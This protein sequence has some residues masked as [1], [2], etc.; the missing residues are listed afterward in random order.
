MLI[1]MYLVSYMHACSQQKQIIQVGR[2]TQSS[3]QKWFWNKLGS[4]NRKFVKKKQTSLNRHRYGSLSELAYFI[5]T[6]AVHTDIQRYHTTNNLYRQNTIFHTYIFI[7]TLLLLYVAKIGKKE[8]N[9]LQS[10]FSLHLD[11]PH[12]LHIHLATTIRMGLY[13]CSAS[14]IPLA[15]D[16]FHIL[17]FSHNVCMH[18]ILHKFYVCFWFEYTWI[19]YI[20]ACTCTYS[21]PFFVRNRFPHKSRKINKYILEFQINVFRI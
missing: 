1:S 3:E 11:A 6:H 5:I 8:K 15:H 10:T 21:F 9:C 2:R 13:I 17:F 16:R 20:W 19:G 7:Y 12:S 18:N 14:L 4:T